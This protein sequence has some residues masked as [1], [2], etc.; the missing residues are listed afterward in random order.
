MKG[1]EQLRGRWGPL[2]GA[3]SGKRNW[4]PWGHG[5]WKG[6][7]ATGKWT[8]KTRKGLESHVKVAAQHLGP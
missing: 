2:G 1:L 6:P 3:G 5:D 8:I 7:K 4:Q